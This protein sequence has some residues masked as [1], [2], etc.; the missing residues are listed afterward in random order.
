MIKN[1]NNL[2]LLKIKRFSSNN[3]VKKMKRQNQTMTKY[4]SEKGFVSRIYKGCLKINSKK[5]TQIK[6]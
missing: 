5:I 1:I 6:N 2:D 3:T 4:I